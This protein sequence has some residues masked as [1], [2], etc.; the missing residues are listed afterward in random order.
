MVFVDDIIQDENLDSGQGNSL[1]LFMLSCVP[2]LG[3]P[4][5]VYPVG[6]SLCTDIRGDRLPGVEWLDCTRSMLWIHA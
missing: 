2:S 5:G 1:T 3:A 6:E 4:P